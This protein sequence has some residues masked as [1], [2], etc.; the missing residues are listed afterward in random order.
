M[1][2]EL[3]PYRPRQSRRGS[4]WVAA[5]M[6]ARAS[7]LHRALHK[8]LPYSVY[9]KLAALSGLDKK[10]L[11]RVTVIAPATLQRRAKTGKFNRDESDRLYRFAKVLK[12]ATDLFEGDKEAAKIWLS[13]PVRGLGG[14]QPVE[15]LATSAETGFVLELIGRLEHGVFT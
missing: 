3:K 14:R 15:M 13:E 12:A 6:P 8:G 5:G 9:N 4:F 2:A 1:S 10:E 11:A 7:E